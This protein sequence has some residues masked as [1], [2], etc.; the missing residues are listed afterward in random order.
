M[1]FQIV[2]DCADRGSLSPLVFGASGG[3]LRQPPP[4]Q[5]PHPI[6]IELQNEL[7]PPDKPA[8]RESLE[9]NTSLGGFLAWYSKPLP[10]FLQCFHSL[11]AIS[12]GTCDRSFQ[13]SIPVLNAW[14][15]TFRDNLGQI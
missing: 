5:L 2:P 8:V 13:S 3:Y 15:T 4:P 12:E 9:G 7:R 10:I 6:Q 1:L 14:T 11:F